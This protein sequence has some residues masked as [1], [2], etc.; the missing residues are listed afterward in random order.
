MANN[1][2]KID[3]LTRKDHSYLRK[4]DEC[5]FYGEYSSGQGATHSPTNQLIFNLKKE[6]R[7]KG[8]PS[9]KYKTSAINDVAKTFTSLSVWNQLE[10]FTWVPI[11]SSKDKT[12]K[13]YDDRLVQVLQEMK[14][15]KAG[16]DFRELV[17][18][19]NSRPAAHGATQRPTPQEHFDN[20]Q[21]NEAVAK[22]APRAIVIFD[23]V[24]VSGSGFRGMRQIL[25]ERFPEV[26]IIGVFVARTIR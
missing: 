21:I 3:D 5:Y 9:W 23:D 13:E 7:F 20:F 15:I 12:H 6:M 24:L 10:D 19:K 11:P 17:L 2:Q 26:P 4:I 22:P 18:L 16:L 8:T 14:K 1:L 25:S